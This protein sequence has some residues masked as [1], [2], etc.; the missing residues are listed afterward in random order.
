MKSPRNYDRNQLHK[1][2]RLRGYKNC[3]RNGMLIKH[4]NEVKRNNTILK[5][6]K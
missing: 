2:I 1:M 4:Q 3:K 6:P 5:F